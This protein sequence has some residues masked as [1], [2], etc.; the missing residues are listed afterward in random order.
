LFFDLRDPGFDAFHLIDKAV[1]TIFEDA[2][3]TKDLPG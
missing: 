3:W 1:A 2:D